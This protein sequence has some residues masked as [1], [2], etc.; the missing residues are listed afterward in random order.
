MDTPLIKSV[1]AIEVK[2]RV[3]TSK[4]KRAREMHVTISYKSPCMCFCVTHQISVF[5]VLVQINIVVLH[6]M[7]ENIV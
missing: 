3:G 7:E 1:C 5:Q 2:T 4:I 6:H